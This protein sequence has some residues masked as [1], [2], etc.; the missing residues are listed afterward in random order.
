MSNRDMILVTGATGHQGGA[1]AR[2]LLADG[3]QV[4]ILT[5]DPGKAVARELAGRGATISKGDLND[6]ASVDLAIK[7]CHGVFSV[8]DFYTA[9]E[10]GE[11]RQGCLLADAAKTAGVKHFVY[12]SVGSA[13]RNTG[14]P[15]FETK[16]KIEQYIR[17]LDLPYTILRPAFFYENF[18]TWNKDAILSGK[19]S[20]PMP[21]DTR[22]QMI[23]VEDIG[24][25]AA[26][27]F[28]NPDKYLGRSIDIAGDELT[29][30]E[31]AALLSSALGRK[32]TYEPAPIEQIRARM[33]ELALMYEWFVRIGYDVEI[34][35]LRRLRPQ[36]MTFETWLNQSEF[37]KAGKE[38]VTGASH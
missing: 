22:L 12:S 1:V 37:A 10:Q 20:L 13:N 33:P 16:Y 17:Y 23:S 30:T 21:A 25:F 18:L 24:G 7:G 27:A 19:L 38:A 8:Q 31:V 29:M 3:W 6:R 32:V 15:H 9:G 34:A 14:I 4:R 26:A 5:R 28:A 35:S 36:M 11:V 2:C